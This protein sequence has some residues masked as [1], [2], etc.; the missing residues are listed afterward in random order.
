MTKTLLYVCGTR[1]LRVNHR[2]NQS[3]VE[4]QTG[5]DT[6][7]DM[8]TRP[9]TYTHLFER[10][11][12]HRPGLSLTH[13][14]SHRI[15][16]G[17]CLLLSAREPVVVSGYGNSSLEIIGAYREEVATVQGELACGTPSSP[18]TYSSPL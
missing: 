4:T 18:I 5:T 12:Y 16:I 9:T 10:L 2:T 6:D 1:H 11:S 8:D 13:A 3:G 17:H 15:V 7:T 14:H